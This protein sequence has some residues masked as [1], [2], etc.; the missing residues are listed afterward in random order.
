MD[1]SFTDDQT[2]I[3]DL[4]AQ[5]VAD[6]D[7]KAAPGFDRAK[8]PALDRSITAFFQRQLLRAQP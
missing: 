5:L 4:A 8:L 3:R 1:F 7:P 6:V 2:S